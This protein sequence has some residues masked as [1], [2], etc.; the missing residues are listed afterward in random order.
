MSVPYWRMRDRYYD[1]LG[2]KCPECG[3]EYFPPVNLCRKC[4][5]D[6][7]KDK[8]MPKNGK[9]LSY[10]MQKES[11][12]GFEDQEPMI[13]GLVELENDVRLVAQIVDCVYESLR[14]G[15]R[16]RMVFRRVRSDGE[17]GQI[18]YGYKFTPFIQR[19]TFE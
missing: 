8:G 9:I 17:S 7:M 5:S 16:V 18:F 11:L 2:N 3:K 1:L 13:F 10:T 19:S 6:N 12:P 15:Q 14:R 4:R